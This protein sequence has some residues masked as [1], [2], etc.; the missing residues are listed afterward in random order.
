MVAKACFLLSE[1]GIEIS[2][3][4]G[5]IDSL[6]EAS[7][8]SSQGKR[9]SLAIGIRLIILSADDPRPVDVMMNDRVSDFKQH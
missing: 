8:Y 7:Y 4:T 9:N 2:D 3:Y 6:Q 1:N 5:R